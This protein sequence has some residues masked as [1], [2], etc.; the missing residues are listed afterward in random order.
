MEEQKD[1]QEHYDFAMEHAQ[2]LFIVLA[3][4]WDCSREEA[5]SK[6]MNLRHKIRI[7]PDGRDAVTVLPYSEYLKTEHWQGVRQYALRRAGDRCQLCNSTER[8][9]VHHRTY[10][11][12]GIEDYRDVIALCH[13]CHAKF[14]DKE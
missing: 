3:H 4:G 12:K 11:R 7:L 6:A 8:L 10:E 5:V 9:E 2:M 1:V 14:H 13:N